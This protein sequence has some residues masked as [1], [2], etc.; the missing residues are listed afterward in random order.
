MLYEFFKLIFNLFL[1]QFIYFQQPI[2]LK[3]AVPQQDDDIISN[4]L[5][6]CELNYMASTQIF[7]PQFF[8]LVDLESP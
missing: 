4:Y 3:H 8:K 6:T 1:S 5:N 7:N 2:T